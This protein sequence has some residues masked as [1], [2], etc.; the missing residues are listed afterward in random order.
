[1]WRVTALGAALL[2]AGVAAA[3]LAG[4][5]SWIKAR[6][7][8]GHMETDDR[9]EHMQVE[10]VVQ[11]LQL[12][13]GSVIADIGAGSGLFTRAMA[14]AVAPG[15]VYAVDINANLLAHIEESAKEA[16][17]SN[18]ETVLATEED[19]RVPEPLDLIFICDVLHL[20]DDPELYLKGLD[21]HI[22]PNGRVAQLATPRQPVQRRAVGAL[23]ESGGVLPRGEARLHS[24][25]ILD[26][27]RAQLIGRQACSGRTRFRSR[28]SATQTVDNGRPGIP[29]GTFGSIL[30]VWL[31][32]FP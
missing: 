17:L 18:I 19:P 2:M 30:K 27:L 31:F 15:V 13:P 10:R 6:F 22:R 16:G 23:D 29:A 28:C 4:G 21:P 3:L 25:S 32:R 14:K 9:V 24:G 7:Y 12:V 8:I 1:M 5:L 20:M 26:D 11:E